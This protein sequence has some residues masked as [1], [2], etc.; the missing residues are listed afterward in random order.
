MIRKYLL[1]LVLMVLAGTVSAV[2]TF[3]QVGELRG[4]VYMQADGKKVPLADAQIDVFRTDVNAKYNTKT[5]KKG[6]FVFAGLPFVGI[7][8]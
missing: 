1:G 8:T 4:H 3:A 2:P 5:N 6:E 7:Y